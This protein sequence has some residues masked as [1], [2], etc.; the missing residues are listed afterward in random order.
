MSRRAGQGG[1]GLIE[2][3]VAITIG[4][5]LLSMLIMIFTSTELT[6]SNENGLAQLQDN[7]RTAMTM[8]NAIVQ[9]AGYYPS[10]QS[11]TAAAAL[12]AAGGFGAGQSILGVSG[13]PD[14][15]SVRFAA[16]PNDGVLNCN[17]NGNTG[18]ANAVYINQFAV[19]AANQ[20]TCSVNGGSAQVL[21]DGVSNMTVLY[22]VDGS[23]SGSVNHYYSAANLPAGAAVRSIQVTLTMANPL[24][25]KP[26][27]P[28]S[29]T[30][31]WLIGLMN[32]L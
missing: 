25:A 5:F 13:P 28:A 18:S 19:N 17:G 32:Q 29:V 20:L 6:E 9:S 7:Q 23:G 24:A 14:T 12:P 27:Q 26:G 30:M 16:A 4:L 21:V 11:Q 10:P 31:S 22:G 2:V 3:M 1:S 15:L 8:I